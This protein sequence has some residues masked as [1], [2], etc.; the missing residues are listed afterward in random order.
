MG[1]KVRR[2]S[3]EAKYG[4]GGVRDKDEWWSAKVI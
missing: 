1:L 3:G 2:P 4:A